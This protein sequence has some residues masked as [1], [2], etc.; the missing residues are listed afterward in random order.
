MGVKSTIHLSRSMA[1]L[2]YVALKLESEKLKR[3]YK[4]K[5]A[6][7]SDKELEDMLEKL[8]DENCGGESFNN[9]LITDEEEF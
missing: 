3:K 6:A 5:A 7:L 4:A 1:E 8:D 9:Y 2:R